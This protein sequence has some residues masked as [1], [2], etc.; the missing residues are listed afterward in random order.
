MIH[1]FTNLPPLTTEQAN[2]VAA[3]LTAGPSLMDMAEVTHYDLAHFLDLYASPEV[4]AHIRAAHDAT[5]DHAHIRLTEAA[6]VA[7]D[8][9]ETL[10]QDTD[11][12]KTE[13]RR[14][15]TTILRALLPRPTSRRRERSDCVP[16]LPSLE[17]SSSVAGS[18]ARG[19]Q[20]RS[21]ANGV[22]RQARSGREEESGTLEGSS[23][24]TP[25]NDADRS[26][27]TPA[28]GDAGRARESH[29][30]SSPVP[31]GKVSVA[32]ST[33]PEGIRVC[34]TSITNAS[35][36]S[37][38]PTCARESTPHSTPQPL[39]GALS[40]APG[41]ARGHRPRSNQEP[42]TGEGAHRTAQ[43]RISSTSH[44]QEHEHSAA[45]ATGSDP[46]RVREHATTPEPSRVREHTTNPD[47][48][49]V[50]E[51]ASVSQDL[52]PTTQDPRPPPPS[53]T[54]MHNCTTDRQVGCGRQS[55][56]H[57]VPPPPLPAA[58]SGLG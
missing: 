2:V 53:T 17:G 46:T 20:S 57:F 39:K 7:T 41:A 26:Q 27:L 37:N 40:L 30:S 25:P 55:A 14:A 11:N 56:T 43:A 15:A 42:G 33:L 52:S 28:A 24:H 23:W 4:R 9:L 34:E 6:H 50:R 19:P 12:D 13:R 48:N 58:G 3:I 18:G 47:P 8:V 32:P 21:D 35:Q 10:A 16:D 31:T 29:F 1:E 44:V 22:S 5:T 36:P 49:R 51:H 45:H 38:L 54:P